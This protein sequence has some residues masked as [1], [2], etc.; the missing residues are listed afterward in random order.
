MP[1]L[2][3]ISHVSGPVAV[4]GAT[5]AG[6]WFVVRLVIHFQKDFT[7]RYSTELDREV[8]RRQRVED[9]NDTARAAQDHDL[10]NAYHR[11]RQL[12]QIILDAGLELPQDDV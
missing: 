4:G 2:L 8:K 6:M 1:W 10:A 12:T 11:I 3:N 5:A 7:D 9:D